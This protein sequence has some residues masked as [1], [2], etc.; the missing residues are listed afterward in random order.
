MMRAQKAARNLL[1]QVLWQIPCQNDNI[2]KILRNAQISE[3]VTTDPQKKNESLYDKRKGE[4][5]FLVYHKDDEENLSEGEIL[6]YLDKK[7][8]IWW[9]TSLKKT[10]AEQDAIMARVRNRVGTLEPIVYQ[11]P[12]EIKFACHRLLAE[13]YVN[14][15]LGKEDLANESLEFATAFINERVSI[16]SRFWTIRAVLVGGLVALILTALSIWCRNGLMSS[17]S[18]IAFRLWMCF[19]S[20]N[21]GAVMFVLLGL[22]TIQKPEAKAESKLHSWEAAARM[23]GGGLGGVLAGTIVELGLIAPFLS[24]TGSK[25][26]SMCAFAFVAGASERLASGIITQIESF[27]GKLEPPK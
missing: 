12:N 10:I 15:L 6:V 3:T 14:A 24:S 19:L 18:I 25:T 11:W 7:L 17:L 4:I 23:I 5:S 26:V 22:G 9:E 2:Q 1:Q 20:G 21:V 8:E 13:A 16:V 27:Q